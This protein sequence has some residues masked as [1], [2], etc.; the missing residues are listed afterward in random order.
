MNAIPSIGGNF[1]TRAPLEKGG[2]WI[3]LVEAESAKL[4]AGHS[5]RSSKSAQGPASDDFNRP[6]TAPQAGQLSGE[7]AASS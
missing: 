6:S 4:T 2:G 5:P 1:H 7:L 3:R